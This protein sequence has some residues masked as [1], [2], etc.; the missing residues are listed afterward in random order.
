MI[1]SMISAFR[2]R[3]AISGRGLCDNSELPQQVSKNWEVPAS[4]KY[5]D[6]WGFQFDL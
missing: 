2:E 1:D 5:T 4:L 6:I 3:P